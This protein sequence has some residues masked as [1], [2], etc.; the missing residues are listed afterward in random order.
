VGVYRDCQ[1]LC[2]AP[3][4]LRNAY[5]YELQIWP[6]H[7]QAHSEQKA[8]KTLETKERGLI[9][10]LPSRAG[11]GSRVTGSPGHRVSDYVRVGSGLGS[12]LFTNRPGI[13]TRFLREQQND[14]AAAGSMLG[15]HERIVQSRGVR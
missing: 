7:S 1:N 8:V 5:S 12:K 15:T 14:T 9:Q 4:Y 3:N 13:V 10:G 6:E 2:G 11:T